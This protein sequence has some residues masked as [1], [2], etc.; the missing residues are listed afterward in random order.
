MNTKLRSLFDIMRF[1]DTSD[2]IEIWLIPC[3]GF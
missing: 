1:R 2:I 3:Y